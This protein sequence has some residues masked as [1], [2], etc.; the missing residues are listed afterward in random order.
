MEKELIAR[1]VPVFASLNLKEP[2]DGRTEL[3]TN[4]NGRKWK[5]RAPKKLKGLVW[6]QE[7]GLGLRGGCG[8]LSYGPGFPSL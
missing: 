2:F 5:K 4:P 7:L 3:E 8:A 6:H 1:L